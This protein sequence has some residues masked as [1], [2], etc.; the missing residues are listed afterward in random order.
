MYY[1]QMSI[2]QTQFRYRFLFNTISCILANGEAP[3][4]LP[5][6]LILFS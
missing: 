5:L 2:N 3:K 6:E 4:S 1:M